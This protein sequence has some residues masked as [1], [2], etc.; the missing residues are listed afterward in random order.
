[1]LLLI[2]VGPLRVILADDAVPPKAADPAAAARQEAAFRLPAEQRPANWIVLSAGD[3]RA[4]LDRKDGG[5][6][7]LSLF[8]MAKQR[9]L[10]PEKSV[11]LFEI[12]VRGVGSKEQVELRA[13][14]GW[15]QVQVAAADPAKNVEIAWQTPSDKRLGELR[16]VAVASPDPS[17]GAIRWKLRVDHLDKQWSIRRVVFP[18]I[19]VNMPGRESVFLCP[20]GPGGLK[21]G[22]WSTGTVYSGTYPSAATTMQFMAAYDTQ[23]GTGLYYGLHDPFGGTKDLRAKGRAEDQS[24]LLAFDVPAENMDV[25]GNGFASPGEAVW[26][27]L[28]GDWFDAAMIY[29]AWVRKNARWF[30]NL[31][32]DGRADTPLWM[33]ELPMWLLTGGAPATAVPAVESFVK[34]AGTPAGVHWYS[35][36]QIPF[37][38]D[39]PHYFPTIAGF[40]EAVRRLQANKVHVMPYI[41]G[42]LWDTRDKGVEDFEF[43]RVALPAATKHEDGKPFIERYNSKESDGSRVQ[44]AV[45]CPSTELWQKTVR[46]IVLR[47]MNECGVHGVYI[48]QVAAAPPVLC[49]D[50]AHGH[51]T[52][53]GHWWTESYWKM[54]DA[55][56]RAKPADRMLTTECNGE[57]Y[58]KYFDGYLTWNWCS[59][60]QVPAFPAVYS[61]SIQMFGRAYRGGD[62]KELALRMKVGQQLVFGEQ[63]GWFG[64]EVAQDEKGMAFVRQAVGLRWQLRRYFY[65]G[66]MARPPKLPGNL[67]TVRADWQWDHPGGVSTD[68]VLTGAYVL[69]AERRCVLLFANVGDQPVTAHLKLDA[70]AY[71]LQGSTVKVTTITAAGAG[72]SFV[73]PPTLDRDVTFPAQTAFAWELSQ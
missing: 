40:A 27:V 7:V 48:D 35:W 13:D 59:D 15:A 2:L 6:R 39:Y 51:L 52:G 37:D 38:N 14:V 64:P 24:I 61:G 25:G 11:P 5:V 54:L 56:R 1:M 21:R 29:R 47:L 26:Q 60:G 73:S 65:A 66:E 67:P 8:D 30:P 18:Q 62:T 16:V 31:T 63:I 49:A 55:I 69:P 46:Q 3:L 57:P 10:L 9:Q 36:H 45:M 4:I 50:H 12:T 42:R 70:A 34:A 43:T 41:N 28:H 72:A 71:R 32:A 58:I 44:L 19:A 33:R 53:G 23:H 22:P 68:A 17:A 20:R